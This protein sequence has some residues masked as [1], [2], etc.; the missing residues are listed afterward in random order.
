MAIIIKKTKDNKC[1]RGYREKGTLI[2]YWWECKLVQTL[3]NSMEIPQKTKNSI[4]WY[5]SVGWG[6]IP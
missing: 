5:G 1:W 3:E 2:H 6:V 4:G